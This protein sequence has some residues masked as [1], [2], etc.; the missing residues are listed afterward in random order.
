MTHRPHALKIQLSDEELAFLERAARQ[1]NGMMAQSEPPNF[2]A[3]FK[4][5]PERM[6]TML[7]NKACCGEVSETVDS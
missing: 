5:T 4:L 6:A 7:V 2:P 3:P 1:I